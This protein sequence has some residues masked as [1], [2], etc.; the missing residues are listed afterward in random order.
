MMNLMNGLF[1][2]MQRMLECDAV[3][4]TRDQFDTCR[5]HCLSSVFVIHDYN[6][7]IKQCHVLLMVLCVYVEVLHRTVVVLRYV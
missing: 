5:C 7:I 2:V 6:N 4:N 1:A 3:S